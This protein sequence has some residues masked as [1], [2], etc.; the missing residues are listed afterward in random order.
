MTLVVARKESGKVHVIGD[1]LVTKIN[2]ERFSYEKCIVKIV[3]INVQCCI[4]FS[5][6]VEAANN[7]IAH[8]IEKNYDDVNKVLGYLERVHRKY[9]QSVDF[10]VVTNIDNNIALHSLKDGEVL[11]DINQFWLG[12]NYNDFQAALG[13]INSEA[14]LKNK[15]QD[16]MLALIQDGN[17]NSIGGFE[18][19]ISSDNESFQFENGM[20]KRS[21]SGFS[22]DIGVHHT[23]C[24][25][26]I[27]FKNKGELKAIEG[28]TTDSL[29]VFSSTN[30]Y[31]PG[32]GLH[33][34]HANSGYLFCPHLRINMGQ[35]ELVLEPLVFKEVAPQEFLDVIY[36]DYD[37]GLKGFIV[38]DKGLLT[39]HVQ[40]NAT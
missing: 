35:P 15:M 13:N 31:F 16:A 18:L 5:G 24:P 10:G 26:I 23:I 22:Y 6:N 20:E 4:C 3:L 36:N 32:V 17:L 8:L 7:A 12:E 25:Q 40:K 27:S 1:T 19:S 29:S 11:N 9:E 33:Y 37:I 39:Y 21:L 34:K 2:G 30:P 28:S 14:P 38:G